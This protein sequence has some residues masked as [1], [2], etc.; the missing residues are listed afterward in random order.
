MNSIVI[1]GA[2]SGL[3]AAMV[4]YFHQ[5]GFHVVGVAR[6]PAKNPKLNELGVQTLVCDATDEEQVKTAV[7]QLPENAFVVSTMG[8]FRADVPVDYIGHRHLINALEQHS[9]QRFLLVTSLG[10]GDSWKYLSERSKQG[11]GAA[12]REKSLAEAWL[13]SSNVPYTILRP[14][15]LKDGEITNR[16]ELSQHVEIHGLIHRSEVAR[17]AHELLNDESC[18]GEIYQCIDPTLSW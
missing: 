1:W 17:L 5:N 10:C 3:G 16:G 2:A 7:N 8:S 14:G 9:I 12:V 15:G 6:N 4:D 11:F 18:L 13:Q